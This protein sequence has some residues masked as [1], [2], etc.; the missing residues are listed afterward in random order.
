MKTITVNEKIWNKL[1]KLKYK[2]GYDTIGEV[3]ERLL[4]ILTEFK[5]YDEF[6]NSGDGK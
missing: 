4:N 3:I 6:K 1:T 2:F 5:M